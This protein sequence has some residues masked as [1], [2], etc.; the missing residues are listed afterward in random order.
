[1]KKSMSEFSAAE[2]ISGLN[3]PDPLYLSPGQLL[4]DPSWGESSSFSP[5]P[6]WLATGAPGMTVPSV[7]T[8]TLVEPV[9]GE[10]RKE[11]RICRTE[12][13]RRNSLRWLPTQFV[14]KKAAP[15]NINTLTR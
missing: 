11:R 13:C 4:S 10:E 6:G 2:R 1:M 14:M 8:M 9:S 5:S 15:A 12:R 3:G 7:A